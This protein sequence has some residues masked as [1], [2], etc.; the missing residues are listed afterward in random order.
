VSDLGILA[1][2]YGQGTSGGVSPLDPANFNIAVPEPAT[3]GFLAL[4]FSGLVGGHRWRI[5]NVLPPSRRGRQG[6]F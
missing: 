3:C 5:K 1:A 4:G 6:Y 2:N